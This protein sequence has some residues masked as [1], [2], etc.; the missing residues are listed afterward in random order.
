MKFVTQ[1]HLKST[2][3]HKKESQ[4][5][6]CDA[7]NNARLVTGLY[8]NLAAGFQQVTAAQNTKSPT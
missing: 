2:T 3:T 7:I 1:P 4:G 6:E 8:E 5:I